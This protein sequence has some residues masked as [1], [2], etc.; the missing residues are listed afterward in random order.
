MSTF[1]R[2]ELL[3][4]TLCATAGSALFGALPAKLA[5]AQN[6]VVGRTLEGNDYRAL[7]CL[8][9]FGGNDSFNALVPRDGA[10][11]SAYQSTRTNLAVPSAELLALNPIS[12]QGFSDGANY[13]LHPQMTGLRSLFN[14]GQAAI[15]ANV[16]PLV[17]PTTKASYDNG[18]V[19]LPA[20]LFSHSDQTVLWQTPRADA[21]ART[22][23]GGR[24]AD[25]FYASNPNQ[26][27][28]MN[29]SMFG[30]N[31]FQAGDLI[32]P[33][34]MS[35]FGVEE[36]DVISNQQ[37]NAN[38]RNAFEAIHAHASGHILER[39]YNDRVG[40]MRATTAQVKD[41]LDLIPESNAV[42]NPF[43]AAFGLDPNASPRPELPFLARQLL[44]VARMIH[45]RNTLG[46][47]RQL[48]FVGMGGFDTHDAQLADHPGLLYQISQALKGFYDTLAAMSIAQR[49]TAFTAS[50]FGRTLSNN[51][52]G[53]DHG[54]GGH[55][56]V[57]GGSVRG[58]RVYG[59]MPSLASSAQNPDDAGWGQI[60]PTLAVDQYA[61]TLASWFGLTPTDRATVFPNLTHF[62]TPVM[63]IQGPDL[64]FMNAVS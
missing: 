30:E 47:E 43:W 52:D 12:G 60:I 29:V 14:S 64:G 36:I 3:H 57:V 22:G 21:S 19:P 55:H 1:K 9:M 53:T 15:I 4:R 24:L 16:G 10:P 13:G 49:V 23:W 38:R 20:Q 56:F 17:R 58:Q 59:R 34:F 39:A 44:M 50:E 2:R 48:F 41:A 51:G 25:I 33:Y 54:W 63:A 37:W 40:R 7:V 18:T 8:Y 45:L 26:V 31:V 32:S 42:F 27:L 28:S 35:P 61:A 11:R 62:T 46:M 5:L 6:A